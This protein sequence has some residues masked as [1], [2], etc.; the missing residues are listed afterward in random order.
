MKYFFILVITSCITSITPP[1]ASAKNLLNVALLDFSSNNVPVAQTEN[2][3]NRLWFRLITA[4]VVTMLEPRATREVAFAQNQGPVKYTDT[5]AAAKIGHFLRADYVVF[6]TLDRVAAGGDFIIYVRV[7]NSETGAIVHADS[8]SYEGPARALDASDM[9][10][11]RILQA[12]EALS[13][14]ATGEHETGKGLAGFAL[15]LV[16]GYI[17]PVENFSRY[18]GPGGCVLVAPGVVYRGFFIGLRSGFIGC[19]GKGG[20]DSACIVPVA[21]MF[22]YS[23]TL[24]RSFSF[25]LTFSG[26]YSYKNIESASGSTEGYGP[27]LQGGVYLGYAVHRN[28][29]LV[30]GIECSAVLERRDQ[31]FLSVNGGFAFSFR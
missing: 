29:R 5:S 31:V 13:P 14:T 4:K 1:A 25:D 17:H 20:S 11:G 2:V 18:A 21:V 10:A 6:G 26:G 9:L 3:K 27:L 16:G 23:F 22:L 28:V 7:V 12:F 8:Q 15:H 19:S 24:P 30:A